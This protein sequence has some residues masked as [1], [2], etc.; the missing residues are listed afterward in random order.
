MLESIVT[1]PERCVNGL[2]TRS[3]AA[4]AGPESFDVWLRKMRKRAGLTQAALGDT[5]GLNRTYI[6]RLEHGASE[7]PKRATRNKLHGVFGSTDDDMIAA[8][9]FHID[10]QTEEE[11]AGPA[12]AVISPPTATAHGEA[13]APTIYLSGVSAGEGQGSGALTVVPEA[14]AK[15]MSKMMRLTW[16]ESR[17]GALDF[18]L[19]NWL[20]LDRQRSGDA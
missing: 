1:V 11:I 16:D 3:F 18:T 20:E 8:G 4:M 6:N 13:L 19:E 17:I 12:P 7:L 9:V 15:L 5:A 10:P 2:G 14:V